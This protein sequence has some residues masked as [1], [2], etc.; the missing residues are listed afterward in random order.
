MDTPIIPSDSGLNDL[1]Y[2]PAEDSFLLLDALEVDLPK[3]FKPNESNEILFALE[4]GCGSG[5][6]SVAVAKCESLLNGYI[7]C[8]FSADININA[9]LL[10]KITGK[11]NHVYDSSLHTILLDGTKCSKN[12]FRTQFDLIICNPPYVPILAGENNEDK[13]SGLLEKSW[14]GGT[15]GNEFIIPFLSNVSQL[16]TP[17]G[18]LY[19]LLSSWN[20]PEMLAQDVALPKGLHGVQIINRAAGRERLS[21]WKFQKIDKMVANV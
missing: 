17:K 7:P 19:M 6:I 14:D 8:V 16:L 4:V 21:V 10:T 1:V 15:D 12:P 9:C 20:N 18:V 5:I 13:Q 3:S 2:D 11:A